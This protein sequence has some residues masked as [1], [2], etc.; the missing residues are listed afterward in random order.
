[1]KIRSDNKKHSENKKID[2][3]N[4]L[5]NVHKAGDTIIKGGLYILRNSI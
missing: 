5:E 2:H 4:I 1:M 3:E